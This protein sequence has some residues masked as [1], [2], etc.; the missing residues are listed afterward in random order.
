[1]VQKVIDGK[2]IPIHCFAE[3]LVLIWP[4]YPKDILFGKKTATKSKTT[5]RSD[6]CP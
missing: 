5:R 6:M 1:M 3:E 4:K 2:N